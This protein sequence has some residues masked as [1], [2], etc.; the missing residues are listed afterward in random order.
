[1]GNQVAHVCAKLACVADVTQEFLD[2]CPE[3]LVN[4]ID[5]DC[6]HVGLI[7]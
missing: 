1:M 3:F 5:A 2:K 4:I 6:N 7:Q